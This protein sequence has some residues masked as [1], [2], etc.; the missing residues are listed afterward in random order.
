VSCS[1]V[2]TRP[3]PNIIV[4]QTSRY[5]SSF[6]N[7]ISQRAKPLSCVLLT[8]VHKGTFTQWP[9]RRVGFYQK[10]S[11]LSTRL[12]LKSHTVSPGSTK[13]SI[14]FFQ[15]NLRSFFNEMYC[16]L[17]SDTDN[18]PEYKCMK[19]TKSKPEKTASRKRSSA[20]REAV[21]NVLD[22]SDAKDA[23]PELAAP[24]IVAEAP[25][26]LTEITKPMLAKLRRAFRKAGKEVSEAEQLKFAGELI[27]A[28][29]PI[30]NRRRRGSP[31]L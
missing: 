31:E 30:L 17:L 18:S 23:M 10:T 21:R 3:Y 19:A 1:L 14:R 5:S 26:P 29:V 13:K 7:I 9:P 15:V 4:A 24:I 12:F 16:Y 27:A 25:A 6:R 22:A 11:L 8:S 2:E 20:E 28:G